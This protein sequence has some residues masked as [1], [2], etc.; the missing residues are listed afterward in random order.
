VTEFSGLYRQMSPLSRRRDD[1]KTRGES[2]RSG[3]K[4]FEKI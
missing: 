1:F 4:F 2:A 3:Q